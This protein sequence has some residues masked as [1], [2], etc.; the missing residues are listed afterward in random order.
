MEEDRSLLQSKQ[1]EVAKGLGAYEEF[2]SRSKAAEKAVLTAQ[3]RFQAVSAGLSSGADGQEETLAAQ[4]IGGWWGGVGRRER[5]S[6]VPRLQRKC[7][8]G[9]GEMVACSSNI[10]SNIIV[11]ECND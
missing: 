11:M 4:K 1:A 6:G 9:C 8:R 5:E 3:Q 7:V 2:Q 10:H